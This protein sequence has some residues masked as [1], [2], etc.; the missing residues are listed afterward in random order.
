VRWLTKTSLLARP[1]TTCST[2]WPGHAATS[3]V[4]T[5]TPAAASTPS[6]VTVSVTP[7]CCFLDLEPETTI[8]TPTSLGAEAASS[9]TLSPETTKPVAPAAFEPG[10]F[11]ALSTTSSVGYLNTPEDKELLAC[12]RVEHPLKFVVARSVDDYSLVTNPYAVPLTQATLSVYDGRITSESKVILM[13]KLME[14]IQCE[15]KEQHMSPQL[16]QFTQAMDGWGASL[17]QLH[18]KY[19]GICSNHCYATSRSFS[20][21]PWDPGEKT[22]VSRDLVLRRIGSARVTQLNALKRKQL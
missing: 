7:E 18:S 1:P 4:S 9:G 11:T 3:A 12:S 19:S 13:L 17:N 10:L 20:L 5:I 21:L 2:K 14:I 6:K 22:R 16:P 8:S 15:T